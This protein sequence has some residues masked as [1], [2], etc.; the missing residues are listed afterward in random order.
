[1]AGF[2]DLGYRQ[3]IDDELKKSLEMNLIERF[4]MVKQLAAKEN[5]LFYFTMVGESDF[6]SAESW[7]AISASL[8]GFTKSLAAE[9][10]GSNVKVIRIG[11]SVLDDPLAEWLVRETVCFDGIREKSLEHPAVESHLI[12]QPAPALSYEKKLELSKDSVVVI[13]GGSGGMASAIAKTLAKRTQAK[14]VLLG[15]TSLVTDL[16]PFVADPTHFKSVLLQRMRKEQGKEIRP[17]ELEREYKRYQTS[18]H[19]QTLLQEIRSSQGEA[20]YLTTDTS[21][22]SSLKESLAEIK[23]RF[24]KID[25][26]IHAAGR[27]VSGQLKNRK[28]ETFR[29]VFHGKALGAYHIT[30]L[31]EAVGAQCIVHFASVAGLFGNKGQIDYC[32]ANDFLNHLVSAKNQNPLSTLRQISINWS[33]VD[34]VGMAAKSGVKEILTS[35]GVDF[36]PISRA[37]DFCLSEIEYGESGAI[38][39]AGKMDVFTKPPTTS[40]PVSIQAWSDIQKH[41]PLIDRVVEQNT[42]SMRL[43]RTLNLSEDLFLEDHKIDGVAYLPGV[44][45]MEMMAEAFHLFTDGQEVRRFSQVEFRSP[46]KIYPGRSLPCNI[47]LK[48]CADGQVA[49]EIRSTFANALGQAIGEERVHFAANLEGGE[50]KSLHKAVILPKD[51][52]VI[53]EAEIYKRYFHGE[54][55]KVMQQVSAIDHESTVSQFQKASEHYF[56]TRPQGRFY[57]DPMHIE[58]VFQS[59]GIF[60]MVNHSNF[61]LPWKLS[62]LE[63]FAD[64][65]R[66]IIYSVNQAKRNGEEQTGY[67]SLVVDDEGHVKI[68]VEDFVM[69][70]KGS[71]REEDRFKV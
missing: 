8:T 38:I 17:V 66:G 18:F 58:F 69:V 7:N 51:T 3:T 28:S 40:L 10:D 53:S 6:R 26:I 11:H 56:K 59:C 1:M 36:I 12:L 61:S 46:I 15:T 48:K 25:V 62:A 2:V 50:K 67:N 29:S 16:S 39:V 55:F 32:A 19:I 13:T 54:T 5:R 43:Q 31:A 49:A 24:G 27:D 37:V 57:V 33:A 63:L 22:Y 20:I 14:I 45:G 65:T 41:Y 70:R 35:A 9:W 21:M 64:E 68:Q 44:M 23:N 60:E 30:R 42:E 34:E 47:V 52:V 71:I 4:E